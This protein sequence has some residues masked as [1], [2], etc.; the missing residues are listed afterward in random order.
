MFLAGRI[1]VPQYVLRARFALVQRIIFT[2]LMLCSFTGLV[3]GQ[4]KQRLTLD[5][6]TAN[7]IDDLFAITRMLKQDQ[8]DVLALTSTQ[9]IHYLAEEDSV[10]ASQR[11]NEALVA[12]LG[13]PDLPVPMGSKEPMG[14]PWGGDEPKTGS[15]LGFVEIR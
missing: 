9:W 14:K 12:L 4:E 5:A 15:F 13:R 1:Q 8:F 6:D 3:T 10:G 7:E 11:E 2:G